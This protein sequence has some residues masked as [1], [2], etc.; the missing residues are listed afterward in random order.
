MKD[1]LISIARDLLACPTAPFRE[2]AVQSCIIDFCTRKNI[3][4]RQ[5]DMGN[6]IAVYGKRYPEAHIA[7][8]AHMDHPGFIIEKDSRAGKTTAMF[9]GGVEE[10]YFAGTGV[11]VYTTAGEITGTI[12]RTSFHPKQRIKRAW[13]SLKGAVNKG[14]T[15]M[16]D[17]PAFKVRGDRLYSRACDDLVGCVAILALLAELSRRRIR[18][19]VTAVFTVA[20]ECGLHGAKYLCMKKRLP[21][22]M[23][24]FTVETSKTSANA[25]IGDGVVIRVGDRGQIF[26]SPLTRFMMSAARQAKKRNPSFKHQRKLMDGGTCESSLYQAFGYCTSALCVPL[27]NYHN[28]NFKQKKIRAEYVSISDL[29]NM[30]ALFIEMARNADELPHYLKRQPPTYIEERRDLGERLFY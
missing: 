24:I 5:D 6:I 1:R 19:R 14:D 27:G 12:T 7:F 18:K 26:N 11:R 4:F 22:S 21:K 16:W 29:E 25:P 17:L 3:H 23:N 15:A 20:E 9:Y 28:R 8:E 2:F 10:E 13:L 30:V